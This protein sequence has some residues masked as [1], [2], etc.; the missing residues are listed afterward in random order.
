M[1]PLS[2]PVSALMI[3]LIP[4]VSPT[5]APLQSS[6]RSI[7]L[8]ITPPYLPSPAT[9]R[10][11]WPYVPPIQLLRQLPATECICRTRNSTLPL[12]KSTVGLLYPTGTHLLSPLPISLLR[13]TTVPRQCSPPPPSS[14]LAWV[15]TVPPQTSNS[16]IFRS[17]VHLFTLL[18]TISPL[19]QV[20]PPL[21]E[22]PTLFCSFPLSGGVISSPGWTKNTQNRFVA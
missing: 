2:C 16:A 21:P 4:L 19:S 20:R 11:I 9:Q 13:T 22:T 8:T 12:L 10:P 15:I 5:L 1:I 17:Y 7:F 3:F 6:I 14:P 18:A